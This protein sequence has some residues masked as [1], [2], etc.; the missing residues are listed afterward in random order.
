M[1][2]LVELENGKTATIK[3][4]EGGPGLKNRLEVMNLREGKKLGK[5]AQHHYMARWS[6]R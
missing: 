1:I 2:T 4:I 3:K 5:H 6:W